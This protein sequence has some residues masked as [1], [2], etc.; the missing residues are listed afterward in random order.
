MKPV[1]DPGILQQLEGGAK[2]VTDPAIVKILE[3]DASEEIG[4]GRKVYSNIPTAEDYY[5]ANA[6]E[7]NPLQAA[8]IA[9]GRGFYTIGRGIGLLEP[10]DKAE[11]AG[12]RALSKEHPISTTIGEVVGEAAP[13]AVAGGPLGS[14][15]STALRT[16]LAGLLGAAEGGIVANAETDRLDEVLKA[17]GVG[18]GAAAALELA[19]PHLGRIIGKA[20]RKIKG[21][22]PQGDIFIDGRPSPEIQEFMQEA[23]IT[24][25]DLSG[26]AVE[27]LKR[28]PAGLPKDQVMR[29]AD[30]ES[31]GAPFTTGDVTQDFAQKAAEA[32]LVESSADVMGDPIRELRLQQDAAFKSHL[33]KSIRETGAPEAFGESLKDA[34]SGRKS[35][36]IADKNRLYEEAFK[37]ADNIGPIPI[38]PDK[39]IEAIPDDKT[40]KRLSRIKGNQIEAAEDMLIEFGL[41]RNP[42]KVDAFLKSGREIEPLSIQNL[43][44]F[45]SGINQIE[46]ADQTGAVSVVTGP[47]KKALD[48]EA[49]L[50]DQAAKKAGLT[51]TPLDLLKEARGT[52]RQVKA[53]FSPQSITGRLIDTKKDG[54]TPVIEASKAYKELMGAQKPTEHLLRTVE[55]LRK[56][57]PK[58]KRAI[59]NLQ[60]ATVMDL[61]DH[62]YKAQTRRIAG[63]KVFGAVPYNNRLE[64]IGD[65]RLN[66]I[67]KDKP[68]ILKKL[69]TI[70]RAAQGATPSGAEM[71]KGSAATILDMARWI[72]LN[73]IPGAG[74]TIEALKM[75]SQSKG[76]RDVLEK[77]LKS[78]PKVEKTVNELSTNFTNIFAV[79]V[80]ASATQ[81]Q[82]EQ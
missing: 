49:E 56:A 75:I 41:D 31:L 40:I 53:E 82:E 37:A 27:Y 42:E 29:A 17:S 81:K 55:S 51:G 45:R 59:G 32:R 3:N 13:F 4:A 52:V 74:L 38:V 46:R 26:A 48:A 5:R 71:P 18:G 33:D 23:G 64:A 44:D 73:R 10:A 11:E 30:Y 72:G 21:R 61:L 76:N 57:G 8:M 63:N 7:L 35:D 28:Q 20:F 1:S 58:G 62:A 54:V 68:E 60:A 70:G 39:L 15:S 66:A 69:K 12:Y 50:M 9:T 2:P 6:E 77:A 24:M 43:E 80:A 36:L 47:I 22:E 79:P 16:T 25:D 14:V 65:E 19:L 67:F 34:L 78:R